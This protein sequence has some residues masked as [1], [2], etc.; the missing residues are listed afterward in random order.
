VRR[1]KGRV[2]IFGGGQRTHAQLIQDATRELVARIER[3]AF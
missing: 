2:P 1:G 3:E